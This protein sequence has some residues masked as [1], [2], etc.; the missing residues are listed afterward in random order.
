MWI[1][2]LTLNNMKRFSDGIIFCLENNKIIDDF[3]LTYYKYF[4]WYV[5]YKLLETSGNITFKVDLESNGSRNYCQLI[6]IV[7]SDNKK[8]INLFYELFESFHLQ[9]TSNYNFKKLEEFFLK[10]QNLNKSINYIKKFEY[11]LGDMRMLDDNISCGP[12]IFQDW[13]NIFLLNQINDS[14]IFEKMY[15]VFK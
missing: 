11:L 10:S 7:E 3:A 9:Y 4:N 1:G 13:E 2:E 5:N 6:S 15:Y 12:A 8:Q 14:I